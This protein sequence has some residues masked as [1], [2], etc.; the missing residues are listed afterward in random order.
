M[1]GERCDVDSTTSSSLR[2]GHVGSLYRPD[3]LDLLEIP[4]KRSVEEPHLRVLD[5]ISLVSRPGLVL[6]FNA[7]LTN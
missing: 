6:T 1:P 4:L 5:A 7:V 2:V 3:L